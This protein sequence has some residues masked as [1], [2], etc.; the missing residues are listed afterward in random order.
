MDSFDDRLDCRFV[1]GCS[2]R[3]DQAGG[4]AFAGRQQGPLDLEKHAQCKGEQSRLRLAAEGEFFD[5]AFDMPLG[6]RAVCRRSTP[7]T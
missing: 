3:T 1:R 4:L 2:G 7:S 5:A 6:V